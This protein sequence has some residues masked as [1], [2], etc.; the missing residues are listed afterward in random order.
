MKKKVLFLNTSVFNELHIVLIDEMGQTKTY[1]TSL[2]HNE[3]G[4]LLLK[5]QEFFKSEKISLDEIGSIVIASGPGG[6]TGLR[7]GASLAMGIGF[8]KAIPVYGIPN[9]KVPTDLSKLLKYKQKRL[10]LEYAKPAVY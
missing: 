5:L 8:G 1:T 3:S 6:F 7:V 4:N 10:R 9:A 2:P